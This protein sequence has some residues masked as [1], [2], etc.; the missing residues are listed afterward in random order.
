MR[1]RGDPGKRWLAFLQNHRNTDSVLATYTGAPTADRQWTED[2]YARTGFGRLLGWYARHPADTFQVLRE[3]LTEGAPEMRP[4]NLGNFRVQGGRPPGART[5][6]LAAWSDLR[7]ALL[8]RWPWH[9]VLW[10]AAFIAVCVVIAARDA[11]PVVWVAI[12]IAVLGTGEFLAASLGD[13]LDAGRHLFLFQAATDLTVCFAAA[14]AIRIIVPAC[15]HGGAMAN[16]RPSAGRDATGAALRC[17]A[18][19]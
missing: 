4:V 10:Y 12:G 13:C 17:W 5:Q 6:R 16:G 18:W 3:T 9:L 14:W 15:R 11:S 7:S 1:R 2:F 19:G 8:R